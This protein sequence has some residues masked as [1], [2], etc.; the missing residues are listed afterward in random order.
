MTVFFSRIC[1]LD[2]GK[3]GSESLNLRPHFEVLRIRPST[4]IEDGG[5]RTFTKAG[6]SLA[7]RV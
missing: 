4:A 1:R 5:F 7:M 3:R 6:S 2:P